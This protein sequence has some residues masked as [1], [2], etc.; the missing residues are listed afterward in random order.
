[1]KLTRKNI[2]F[3]MVA[4]EVLASGKLSL[5]AKG[6]YAYLF[7]KPD[8]WDFSADRIQNE[9]KEERKAVLRILKELEEAGLLTRSRQS[10]GRVLYTLEFADPKSQSGTETKAHRAKT[11]PVSKKDSNTNT[12]EET[13]IPAAKPAEGSVR[14]K[15]TSLGAD[16]IKEF[17]GVDPKNKTYYNNTSQRKAADFLIETYGFDEVKKRIG[18]LAR[19]NKLP[20]FPTITTP[21]QLRDKWVPLQDAVERLRSKSG[22]KKAKVA[23]V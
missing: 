19:T 10:N 6:L 20:Y 12:E 13:N 5:K 7:S 15:F 21:V 14:S 18:V 4:N 8:D 3:T 17:E 11:V 2:P 16:V 1:M 23:F 22:E 9:C